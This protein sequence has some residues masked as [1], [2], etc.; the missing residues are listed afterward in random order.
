MHIH[1]LSPNDKFMVLASDGVWE[2]LESEQVIKIVE[3]CNG[4]EVAAA[5]VVCVCSC[6]HARVNMR[7]VAMAC[8]RILGPCDSLESG[9]CCKVTSLDDDAVLVSV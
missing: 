7:P 5:K 1:K 3:E 8:A 6:V 9:M 4:N 2:F